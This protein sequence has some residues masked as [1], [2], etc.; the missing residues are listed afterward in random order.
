MKK[1]Y[2][3]IF[4]LSLIYLY[5]LAMLFLL[6]I[7]DMPWFF[8]VLVL[9]HGGIVGL[10]LLKKRYKS[11]NITFYYRNIYITFALFI[12]I[13]AYKLIAAIFSFEENH[14][15]VRYVSIAIIMIALMVGAVNVFVF[16]KRHMS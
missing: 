15:L 1:T 6:Q 16:K 2:K 13:L 5:T 11:L 12:P 8:L 4:L 7:I 9:M 3:F 10:I 14:D